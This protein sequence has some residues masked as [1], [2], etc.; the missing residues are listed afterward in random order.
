MIHFRKEYYFNE[1]AKLKA[2]QKTF[3]S[4]NL[5]IEAQGTLNMVKKEIFR[6]NM[7]GKPKSRPNL[8]E[9]HS[10]WKMYLPPPT[11]HLINDPHFKAKFPK[12]CSFIKFNLFAYSCLHELFFEQNSWSSDFAKYLIKIYSQVLHFS[13]NQWISAIELVP[14]K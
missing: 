6:K 8:V 3:F 2:N 5:N 12:F 7:Q 10:V 1:F 14:Y 9:L 4:N 13:R 11:P